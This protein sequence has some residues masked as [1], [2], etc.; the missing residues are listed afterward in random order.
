MN[1]EAWGIKRVCSRCG[2]RF[3]DLNKSPILCPNCGEEFDVEYMIKKKTKLDDE[4]EINNIE[5]TDLAEED[6]DIGSESDVDL[7]EA[8]D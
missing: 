4:A 6:E 2:S 1:K 8:E 7:D 5:D 3:Y